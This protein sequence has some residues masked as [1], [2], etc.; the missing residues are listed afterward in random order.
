MK[1]VMAMMLTAALTVS[2]AAVAVSAGEAEI[3][4]V[5]EG[6]LH[7][8]TNAAFPPYEMTSDDGGYEG[9]DVEIATAI[10]EKL[11]LELVVDDMDFSSVIASVQS[12]KADIAMAGLTVNEERKKNIDFT[13]TYA[14]GVQVIIVPEGSEIQSADDLSSDILIGCQEATTGYIYCSDDYGE[15][16]VIAYQNGATAIQ[17]LLSGKVDCIVI[18]SE[19]AKQFVEANEGLTILDTEYVTED[20]A[21]GISKENTALLDA[22]NGALNELIED[23]T[24]EEIIG[25]YISAE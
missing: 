24:V 3:T 12:G 10:A 23:G 11:G 21:I 17:A 15:D 7:M 20:Y 6:E 5:E 22:V 14:T 2:M 9:I 13:D 18:D 19:P 4:T 25:K 8:A 16:A 1:K